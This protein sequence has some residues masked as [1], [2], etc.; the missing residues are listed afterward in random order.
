MA[1]RA[2]LERLCNGG[3]TRFLWLG[4]L[5]IADVRASRLQLVMLLAL[6]TRIESPPAAA[7]RA[8]ALHGWL[9]NLFCGLAAAL[10]VP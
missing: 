10:G 6:H 9:H 1:A 3:R 8:A 7:L 2:E 5:F 4:S